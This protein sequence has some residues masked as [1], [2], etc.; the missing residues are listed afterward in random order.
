MAVSGMMKKL[1][2][3]LNL[4]YNASN[5]YLHLSDWCSD[6][7][8]N[9]TATFLRT[10]AQSNVTLMMRMFDYM[11]QSGAMPVLKATDMS[12]EE[13]SSLEALFQRTLEEYEQRHH[14][15]NEIAH[16]AKTMKDSDTLDFLQDIQKDQQQDGLLLKTIL[17]EVRNA[18]RAGMCQ[19]QTDRHLLNIVTYQHH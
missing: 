8:L 15:L 17:D 12:E 4:E 3:Q 14:T 18:R 2:A 6:N 5:L 1:N 10:Q 16:D 13:Y 7:S 11:K 19:R 9:G